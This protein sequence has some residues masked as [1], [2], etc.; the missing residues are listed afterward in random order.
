MRQQQTVCIMPTNAHA[1]SHV[2]TQTGSFDQAAYAR[3]AAALRGQDNILLKSLGVMV[4][5]AFIFITIFRALHHLCDAKVCCR[6]PQH[7]STTTPHS[8]R[9]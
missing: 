5:N 8:C 6:A 1:I 3:E 9:P 4:G 2:S 7:T